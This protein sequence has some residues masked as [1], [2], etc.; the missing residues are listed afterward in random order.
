MKFLQLVYLLLL[1]ASCNN[2]QNKPTTVTEPKNDTGFVRKQPSNPFSTPDVS[3]LDISYFPVDYPVLK[4]SGAIEKDPVARVIYSRP[5]RGGR[6]IFGSLLKYGEAWRL[7]ANE[8]TE[9]E[10]FQPVTIQNKTVQKGR[11]IIYCIPNA[12]KWTIVFNSNIYTWGL[13]HIP[14]TPF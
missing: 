7:G 4:M 14:A 9:I 3:P 10:F 5:H 12:E 6:K 8:S 2:D 11:Y 13:K 1:T